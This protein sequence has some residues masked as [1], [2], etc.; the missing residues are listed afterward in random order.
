MELNR[1][2]RA[3]VA[4]RVDGAMWRRAP[5]LPEPSAALAGW[6]QATLLLRIDES[7][8]A[9]MVYL[10]SFAAGAR[11]EDLPR[12]QGIVYHAQ[13]VEAEHATM[14]AWLVEMT[15]YPPLK[16]TLEM[17]L[18]RRR[19]IETEAAKTLDQLLMAWYRIMLAS[20]ALSA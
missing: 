3:E 16:H 9:R 20:E 7:L 1:L 15:I 17:A 11:G 2:K 12:W 5:R 8:E 18:R 4:G 14:R 6:E 19:R 13:Q 10:L